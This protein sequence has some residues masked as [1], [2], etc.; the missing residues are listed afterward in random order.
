M[1]MTEQQSPPMKL[2]TYT[3]STHGAW[4]VRIQAAARG[5]DVTRRAIRRPLRIIQ[6]PIMAPNHAPSIDSDAT[7]EASCCVTENADLRQ[8]E[9][10]ITIAPSSAELLSA[11]Q[12]RSRRACVQ[13]RHTGRYI[14]GIVPACRQTSG[15]NV[16]ALD[17]AVLAAPS[18]ICEQL[19]S[20]VRTVVTVRGIPELA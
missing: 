4:P 20:R 2:V 14:L 5:R 12:T 15:A 6:S 11:V 17:R 9:I 18:I 7:H 16:I 10:P 3:S 8:I 19:P 1:V 13:E